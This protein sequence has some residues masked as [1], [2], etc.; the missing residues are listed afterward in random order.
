MTKDEFLSK[1]R[2]GLKRLPPE[3]IENAMAYYEEYLE[4]AGEENQTDAV[5]ALGSPNKI[6]SQIS[7]EYAV[8]DLK[9]DPSA[10]KGLAA[11]WMVLLAVFASPIAVPIA[12]AVACVA[13]AM[14]IVVFALI[15]SFAAVAL[16]LTLAGIVCVIVGLILT[17]QNF[18]VALFYIGAGLVTLGLGVI[19]GLLVAKLSKKSFNGIVHMISKFLPR[20]AVK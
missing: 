19:F 17:V 3:E 16:S 14:V 4:D 5:A 11:V 15:F 9:T 10:K 20:R 8:K 1:L 7:A 13:F 18:P 12:I 2:K 6:A